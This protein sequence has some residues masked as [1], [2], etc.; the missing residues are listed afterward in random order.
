M[1]A[2][3]R[4]LVQRMTYG[5]CEHSHILYFTRSLEAITTCKYEPTE[6]KTRNVEFFLIKSFYDLIKLI[7]KADIKRHIWKPH[8]TIDIGHVKPTD[9][10]ISLCC[11]QSQLYQKIY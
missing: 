10:V 4:S 1:G 5:V 2:V 9:I 11:N 7:V 3:D 8:R 6:A